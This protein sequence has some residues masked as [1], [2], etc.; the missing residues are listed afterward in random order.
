MRL[1]QLF[2][3]IG[4]FQLWGSFSVIS[5]I[6]D[7]DVD[8]HERSLYRLTGQ[9]VNYETTHY[10][11]GMHVKV[12]IDYELK[13]ISDKNLIL[14]KRNEPDFD[15]EPTFT[16]KIVSRTELFRLGD[17]IDEHY[18]GPSNDYSEK[19]AH[20]RRGLDKA[21][22][23]EN[24]T[25]AVPSG[26]IW[27]FTSYMTII[28]YKKDNERTKE[29]SFDTYLKI[30]PFW[31]KTSY[32]VWSFNIDPKGKDRGYKIGERLQKRWARFGHLLLRDIHSEPIKVDFRNFA[33][34]TDLPPHRELF[35]ARPLAAIQTNHGTNV[36]GSGV[37]PASPKL[38]INT[39]P[40]ERL[41]YQTPSR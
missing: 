30:S 28:A 2:I 11:E 35:D 13:N 37:S 12:V 22:P 6:P 10:P 21:S 18:G 34:S 7:K 5:Q 1:R 3:L 25:A 23:P 8:L 32:E 33:G 19:W 41:I 14:W 39:P 38:V 17:I 29:L 9:V 4:C 31:I 24:I 40:V 16:G 27:K 20:L 26:E 15:P 36:A